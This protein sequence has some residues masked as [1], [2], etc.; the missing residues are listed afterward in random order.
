MRKHSLPVTQTR[1]FLEPGP[2]VLI[3]SAYKSERNIM[4]LGWHMMLEYNLVGCF[5]WDQNH[6]E[7]LIRRSKQCVINLPTFDMI[8]TIIGIGN[9]HATKDDKLDKFQRF[10]LTPT[11]AKKVAAPLIA[12]CH[13]NFECKLI[14][15]SQIKK[16]SLFI[17]EVV[18]AHVTKNPKYPTTV[19]YRGDGIFMISGPNKSYRSKFKKVNL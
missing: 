16:Y 17:F 13:S 9:L 19:H 2:I 14:D 4:T 8:D 10:H 18:H 11:P 6:S 5:I 7:Q 15:T 12:E 1:R 3:S